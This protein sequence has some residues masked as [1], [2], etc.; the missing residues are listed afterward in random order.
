MTIL[1]NCFILL[2]LYFISISLFGCGG[3]EDASEDLVGTWDLVTVDGRT[4]V[5]DIQRHIG[6]EFDVLT[7]EGKNIFS[8]DGS[9]F[10]EVSF[11]ALIDFVKMEISVTASGSYVISDSTVELISGDRVNVVVN[12]TGN[13]EGIS[14]SDIEQLEREIEQQ[15]E[16]DFGLTTA[17]W[18][19]RLEGD[20]LTL[21]Q[22]DGSEEV[23]K[24][25]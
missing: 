18:T 10:Q 23:Y 6:N 15:G 16:Q 14:D 25:K 2:L 19:W 17:T 8:S 24:K 12:I 4:P 11:S 22:T 1:R 9:F 20:I 7:A 5:G 21:S 13:T 3:D